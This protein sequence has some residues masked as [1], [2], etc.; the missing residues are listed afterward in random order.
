MIVQ[1][2]MEN[3]IGNYKNSSSEIYLTYKFVISNTERKQNNFFSI[4]KI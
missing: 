4:F 2:P 1:I 3:F